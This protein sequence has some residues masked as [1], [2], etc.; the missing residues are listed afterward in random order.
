[1]S[2]SIQATLFFGACWGHKGHDPGQTSL[3]SEGPKSQHRVWTPEGLWARP[4]CGHSPELRPRCPRGRGTSEGALVPHRK[5][6]LQKWSP[7]NLAVQSPPSCLVSGGTRGC[8]SS[9]ETTALHG[10]V[11]WAGDLETVAGNTGATCDRGRLS[12]CFC[13]TAEREHD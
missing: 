8:L 4:C 3:N 2:F 10:S 1:M 6:L 7:W 11:T 13:V 5:Q 9:S 12:I